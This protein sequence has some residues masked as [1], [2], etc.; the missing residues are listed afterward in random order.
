[1]N[2]LRE[3]CV[4]HPILLGA[5]FVMLA[6]VG[7]LGTGHLNDRL[8]S[9]PIAEAKRGEFVD[10][11]QLRGEMKALRS[12]SISAPA[13]AGDLLIV[14]L[15]ADGSHV[16]KGDSV[17]E[18]DKTRT[19]QDLAQ[20]KSALKAAQAEIEQTRAQA[21]L[22][23]E[24]DLTAVSKA[25]YDLEAA[26]L[27]AGKQEII[28]AI[29]GEKA[30]L[31]VT[32]A[33]QKLKEAE[34]KLKSDRASSKATIANKVK[35]GEKAAFDARHALRSLNEMTLQSPSDGMVVLGQMWR[36]EGEAVFKP[37]DRAWA[38]APIAEIPD[39][40]T[41]RVTARV[42]E[43][44]RGRL[45]EGQTVSLQLEAIPDRQFTAHIEEIS[46]TASMD[47]SAGWPFPRN[48]M[49]QA[50]VDQ[51]DS[52]LRPGMS[53]QLNVIVDK[54]SNVVTIPVQ[55]AFQKSGRTVVYVQ[56]GSVFHEQEIEAR[57]RS[58]NQILVGKGLSGG[59]RLALADPTGKQ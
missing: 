33:E 16:K 55:A 13:G 40:S 57:R 5:L 3:W 2:R 24:A 44:E 49:L 1:M 34:Q 14:K 41:L 6:G 48:F 18:F 11:M 15:A 25:K 50:V 47:F 30:R 32:D 4:R 37:G 8:T 59:E 42:D 31:K 35:A 20:Y 38:G 10:S 28:S 46:T 7:L 27:E 58:G 22:T 45:L 43:T 21:R 17:V 29:D 56:H 12:L 51:S 54:V 36:P 26:R 53:A 19:E 9:I 39:A 52:R 23:D